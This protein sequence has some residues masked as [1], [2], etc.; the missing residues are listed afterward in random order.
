[1]GSEDQLRLVL[2]VA[3]AVKGQ[4]GHRGRTASRVWLT[5]V[6]KI[7]VYP[8]RAPSS[9]GGDKGALP[10]ITLPDGTL[11]GLR[12]VT[13]SDLFIRPGTD[14]LWPLRRPEL[15]LLDLF[16]EQRDGTVEDGARI[17]VG[18]LPAQ[19]L[20]QTPK[21]QAPTSAREIGG[22]WPGPLRPVRARTPVAC[23]RS[24]G[25]RAG[26]PAPPP[27]LRSAGGIGA[28]PGPGRPDGSPA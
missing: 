22:A 20:L 15:G 26:A 16:Q 7:D 6:V 4:V 21:L 11:H 17:A 9:I 19:Q 14:R 27:G 2:V 25:R 13:G 28:W 12:D 1:M 24:W 10:A 3:P 5:S 18:D 23:G 8:L